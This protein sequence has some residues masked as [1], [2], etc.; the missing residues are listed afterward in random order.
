M[1]NFIELW[2]NISL[3]VEKETGIFVTVRVNMGK[4]VY[5]TEKGCPDDGEDVLILQGTRNPFHTTESTKWREAV[6]NIVEEIKIKMK[7][8]TVQIIFQPIELVYIKS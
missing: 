6:I 4:V 5:Q 7:Q 1:K 8:V 2:R 3:E